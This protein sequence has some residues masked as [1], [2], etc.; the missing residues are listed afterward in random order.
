VGSGNSEVLE[1]LNNVASG[2]DLAAHLKQE[3][4][5]EVLEEA[6]NRVRRRVEPLSWEAFRLTA[7]DNLAGAVAAARLGLS[8][9]AVFKAKGRILK[10]LQEEVR[11][12]EALDAP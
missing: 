10:M 5:R 6:H 3:F 4:D 2:D 9:A 7:V 8:V 1:L 12:L 11:Q